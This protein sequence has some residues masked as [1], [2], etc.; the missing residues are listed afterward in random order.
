[1]ADERDFDFI[2]HDKGPSG[3]PV[4]GWQAPDDRFGSGD[5]H[6]D[7]SQAGVDVVGMMRNMVDKGL[8]DESEYDSWMSDHDGDVALLEACQ[9]ESPDTSGLRGTVPVKSAEACLS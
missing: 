6:R 9:R 8:M 5:T 1:M 7:P 3:V 2:V 4:R